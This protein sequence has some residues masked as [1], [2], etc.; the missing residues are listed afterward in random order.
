MVIIVH[1][2]VYKAVPIL[3]GAS[4]MLLNDYAW[5]YALLIMLV[6][7]LPRKE[8]VFSNVLLF[9]IDMLI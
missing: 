7:I 3:H 9:Q 8:Y 2:F 4:A 6:M 1:K 5:M